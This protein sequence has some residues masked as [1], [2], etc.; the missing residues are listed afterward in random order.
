VV[1]ASA[2][3]H[4][5]Q[6]LPRMRVSRIAAPHMLLQTAPQE[7]WGAVMGFLDHMSSGTDTRGAECSAGMWHVL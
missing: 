7:A 1:P 5:M 3:Q 4:L 6:A 2:L